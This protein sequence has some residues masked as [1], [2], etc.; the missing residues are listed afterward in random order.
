[1]AISSLEELSNILESMKEIYHSE[2]GKKIQLENIINEKQE[3]LNQEK[4][5]S[6]FYTELLVLLQDASFEGREQSKE[7]IQRL[8]TRPLQYIFS[9]NTSFE[10]DLKNRGENSTA[11]FWVNTDYDYGT[12]STD[13]TKGDGGGLGDV[14]S[15]ACLTTLNLSSGTG[16]TA[17]L[18]L[19]EPSKYVSEGHSINV[20]NFLNELSKSFD[21]Q[22]IMSTHD[23]NIAG[24]SDKAFYFQLK[25]GVS[26][27]T[28][29]TDNL[30]TP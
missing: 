7:V 13:P 17:P 14:T 2:N 22:I 20:A 30:I 5:N 25:N 15:L 9:D 29:I 19:D 10:V 18:V 26:E 12:V 23:K 4:K 8:V 24:V 3:L 1:M 6:E 21:K 11:Q 16:V 28:E 27:V